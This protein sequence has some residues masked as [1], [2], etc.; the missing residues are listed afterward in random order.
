MR[1][2][3][4]R[5]LRCGLDLPA[6]VQAAAPAETPGEPA[7]IWGH[8][9]L[10]L[11]ALGGVVVVGGVV[12]ILRAGYQPPPPA[13]PL[14]RPLIASSPADAPRPKATEAPAPL[15]PPVADPQLLGTVSYHEGDYQSAYERYRAAIGRNPNDAESL[16]NCGQV[17]I[18]LGRTEESVP[19]FERAAQLNPRRWAYRFNLARACGLLGQW[20]RA[21][22]EYQAAAQLFPDDHATE[23]NLGMALHK[24]GD[25]AAAVDHFRKAIELSPDEADFHLS[26]AI[27]SERLGRSADALEGFRR[28]LELAPGSPETANVKAH[29]TALAAPRPEAATPA[30]P[31]DKF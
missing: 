14:S 3:R 28:Y 29:M 17:L 10:L 30:A 15:V 23:Y 25:E 8:W 31:P 9:P 1:H 22:R 19:L 5:C 12:V 7:W 21:V 11:A 18:R 16:S 4:R 27:S 24:R 6:R 2:D 26:L 20:D 13:T